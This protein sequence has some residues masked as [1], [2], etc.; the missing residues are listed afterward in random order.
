MHPVFQV[1][2][3]VAAGFM[4]GWWIRSLRGTPGDHRLEGELREQLQARIAEVSSLR[5]RL[6]SDRAAQQEQIMASRT[7]EAE[8]GERIAFLNERLATERQQIEALQQRFSRDFEAISHKLLVDNA[9]RFNQQSAESL[10]K[11]L[12][13]LRENLGHFK[14]SLDTTRQEAASHSALLKEQVGRIGAEAANLAKALKGDAKVLGNWGE[15]ML[16]KLLEKSGL[17]RDVHYRRQQGATSADGAQQFL[18]VV[19]DLPEKR[20]LI[21]DS[22]LS[23]RSFEE[24]CNAPDEA[25]RADLMARHVDATRRHFRDLGRKRYHASSGMNAPDFVLMYIPIESA[26]FSAIAQDPS[27]FEEAMELGV[28]LVTN[29]T[30]LPTL[31]TVANVWRLADQQKNAIEIAERGGRLHDKFVGFVDDL[32]RVGE[33]LQAGREAWQAANS[34]LHTG[35]GNL[36]RQAGQLK[37]LGAKAAKDLPEAESVADDG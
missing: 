25:V 7:R 31:R 4:L 10:D 17:Q 18:D 1:M 34:K 35:P 2:L 22:K 14:A 21:V 12:A 29:S 37:T 6:E 11:L 8:M 36:V 15:N 3:G 27:L 20:H 23:L 28:V 13:P 30:L 33:A 19:I 32:R 16:E 26:Y 9:A 24:A 5:D